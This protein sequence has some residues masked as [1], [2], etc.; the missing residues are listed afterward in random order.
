MNAT[1]DPNTVEVTI[2][3][4]NISLNQS[5]NDTDYIYEY[6]YSNVDFSIPPEEIVPVALLYGLTFVLGAVGNSLVIFSIGH[7]RRMQT[8]T[9]V[10][11]MSLSTADLL[12]I[13]ICVPVKVS[14]TLCMCVCAILI[15]DQMCL[16]Y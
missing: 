1:T 10:F 3:L 2:S 15:K 14:K 6:D 13:L 9:N 12:V 7:F 5:S 11:L 8:V 16:S 4:G